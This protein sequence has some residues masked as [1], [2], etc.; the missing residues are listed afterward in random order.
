MH[1][2]RLFNNEEAQPSNFGPVLSAL[3]IAA[4]GILYCVTRNPLLAMLLPW[5]HATGNSA[6]S[7]LP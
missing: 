7:L 4:A 5:L 1:D 6:R 3:T 2:E